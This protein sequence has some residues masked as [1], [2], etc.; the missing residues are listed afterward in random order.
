MS[1][2][3]VPSM[4]SRRSIVTPR[5]MCALV[6]VVSTAMA[7][8]AV[9]QTPP[10]N[11]HLVDDH[12]TAWHPPMEFPEGAKV[13]T[14]VRG[15]TLWDLS[16]EFYGDSYLW[17]QLWEQNQYI[18]DAHWIYPGDPLVVS[19]EVVPV[20][21]LGAVDLGD[22][23][24]DERL[25]LGSGTTAPQPLGTED[26][27]YCSGYIGA[28]DEE[29][30]Y[31]VT[32]SEY[33]ALSPAVDGHA[34]LADVRGV[35]GPSDT[36]KVDLTFGD[37]VYV[38]GGHDGGLSP[39]MVFTVLRRG[40]EIPN[41]SSGE[42]EGRLFHY[43][44]RVRIL[45]VQPDTAIAEIVHACNS[46]WVGD[47]LKPFV[48]EP[49]PLGRRVGSIPPNDPAP[50]EELEGK[51]QILAAKDGNVSLGQDHVVFIDRGGDDG[52]APGDIYTIYRRNQD[53]F[54]PIVLGELAVLSVHET[55][56]VAKI[57]ESRYT[58]YIGDLL[59]LK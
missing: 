8:A 50:I 55:S 6:A 33:Q 26:D 10:K 7:V 22:D 14:I 54:P 21:E 23:G 37:I 13:H 47:A 45:S 42:V 43:H 5:R 38:D 28:V 17:P 27:I 3:E 49:V 1:R 56:S 44:G 53:G 16:G 4:V 20:D 41:R 29:F 34:A 57:L 59:H 9:A 32:G 12:W 51:G 25:R 36:V 15:D 52:A 35:Y 24:D 19:V 2:I 46:V 30:G 58:I 31:Q 11:L 48:P 18:E 39:G 40:E